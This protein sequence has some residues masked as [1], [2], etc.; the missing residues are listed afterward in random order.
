MI[1]ELP[2]TDESDDDIMTI[3]LLLNIVEF[4]FYYHFMCF[5]PN[6]FIIV[7]IFMLR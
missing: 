4:D 1:D 6:N 3:P 2:V 7:D 5:L